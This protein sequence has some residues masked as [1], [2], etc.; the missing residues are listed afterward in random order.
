M[1][2]ILVFV[3]LISNG[4]VVTE[5]FSMPFFAL[6]YINCN[7]QHHQIAKILPWTNTKLP[8]KFY[9]FTVRNLKW[10]IQK[11]TLLA[12]SLSFSQ[13]VWDKL[14]QSF[15]KKLTQNTQTSDNIG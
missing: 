8:C 10:Y 9:L 7:E 1:N 5:Y 15:P 2:F 11:F 13:G 4:P 3:Y 14:R 12:S 6:I